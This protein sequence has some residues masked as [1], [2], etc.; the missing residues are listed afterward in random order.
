MFV[1]INVKEF[2]ENDEFSF[3]IDFYAMIGFVSHK[4]DL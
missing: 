3:V 2:Y 1:M 4:S